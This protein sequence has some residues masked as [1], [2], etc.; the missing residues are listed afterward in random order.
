MSSLHV[1]IL[2]VSFRGVQDV[3]DCLAAL[4]RSEHRDFSVFICENGGAE[5]YAALQDAIPGKL[6]GGQ[7]VHLS[8][9]AGNLGFAGGVNACLDVAGPA[10]AYW[11]L[12]PDTQPDPGALASMV[13]R[14]QEGDCDMVGHDIVL[15]SGLLA[16]RSGRWSKR[17]ARAISIDHGRPRA[18]GLARGEV[19]AA[20]N[21][22]IG[23]SMLVSGDFFERFG[24]MR[25]DYFLYCEEAEWCL[26]AKAQ[27]ARLG[28]DQ[29]AVVLHAHGTSTGGGGDL[30]SR[31]RIAV[32]LIERNRVLL[33]RDCFPALVPTASM[34][35]LLHLMLRC[36]RASAWR[37]LAYGV[38]GWAAGLRD[39]RGRPAWF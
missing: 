30:R 5:A 28:Y 9:S 15:P 32:Y 10:D 7:S 34:F 11:I 3:V 4:D 12:N 21:Y 27:G 39:E 25:E 18:P 13:A 16:S 23:A 20:M 26:R 14:L 29:T 35:A 31:S 22:V 36:A 24:R 1:A 37:Q 8:L 6:S 19:E 33:T 17:T 38:S 2:I